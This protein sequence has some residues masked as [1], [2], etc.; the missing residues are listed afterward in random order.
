MMFKATRGLV[1]VLA[2]VLV[3]GI[4]FGL[5]FLIGSLVWLGVLSVLRFMF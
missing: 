1:K 5:L 3:Y 2:Y 4:V